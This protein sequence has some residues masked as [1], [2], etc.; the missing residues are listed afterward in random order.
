VVVVLFMVVIFVGGLDSFG[1][2][3]NLANLPLYSLRRLSPRAGYKWQKNSYEN[4]L[5][6]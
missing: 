3:V 6:M 1:G 5:A 4:S 2:L